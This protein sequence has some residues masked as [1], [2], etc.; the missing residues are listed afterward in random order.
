M[1]KFIKIEANFRNDYEEFKA[2]FHNII[3]QVHH[4]RQ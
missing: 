1:P 4:I 3:A 2:R